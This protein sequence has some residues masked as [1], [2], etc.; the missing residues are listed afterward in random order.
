MDDK[1]LVKYFMDQTN[2]RLMGIENKLEQLIGF[3]WML[4]GMAAVI[5]CIVSLIIEYVK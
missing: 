3:R 1:D 5:S 4:I 2:L